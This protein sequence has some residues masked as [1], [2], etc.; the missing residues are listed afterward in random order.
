MQICFP[1]Q[2][3]YALTAPVYSPAGLYIAGE[4]C[5]K[6]VITGHPAAPAICDVRVCQEFC[7]NR[8]N[9]QHRIAA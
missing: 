5:V 4:L 3:R 6:I 1:E 8:F 2:G 7:V 9:K